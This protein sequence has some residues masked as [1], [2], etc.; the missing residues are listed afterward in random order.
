MNTKRK[1][2]CLII[3]MCIIIF[4]CS[5]DNYKKTNDQNDENLN[6][7]LIYDIKFNEDY[8]LE[9]I[10]IDKLDSPYGIISRENDIIICDNVNNYIIVLDKNYSFIKTIGNTGNDQLEFLNPTGIA[11]YNDNIYIVN[12]G[13]KRIQILDKNFNYMKSI[14][15]P[16]LNDLFKNKYCDISIDEE[17]KIYLTTDSQIEENAKIF[18]VFQD[19]TV[20]KLP[21]TISYGYLYAYNDTVYVVNKHEY[22]KT[23]TEEGGK[24][25]NHFLYSIE[26]NEIIEKFKFPDKYAPCDFILTNDYIYVFT[27][28]YRRL[29]KF[30]LDGKYQDSTG[31]SLDEINNIGTIFYDKSSDSF[32]LTCQNQKYIYMLKNTNIK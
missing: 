26:N 25:G 29:D 12:S 17:G 4:I 5:C 19:D 7:N 16:I 9:K 31:S 32:Y 6:N 13:N 8:T 11:E 15:L 21:N 3:V 23:D 10:F 27:S 28:A 2:L 20:Q 1:F 14:K 18:I 30:S 22:F 24:A